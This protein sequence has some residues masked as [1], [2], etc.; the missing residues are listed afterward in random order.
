MLV[1]RRRGF[2]HIVIK[3][4]PTEEATHCRCLIHG[5]AIET[6]VAGVNDRVVGDRVVTDWYTP[7][8]PEPRASLTMSIPPWSKFQLTPLV[9]WTVTLLPVTVAPS[10]FDR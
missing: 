9:V 4:I 8:G 5:D 6:S 7:S 1:V 2:M 10:E 3:H